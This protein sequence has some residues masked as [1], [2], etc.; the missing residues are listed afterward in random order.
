MPFD[1]SIISPWHLA[2]LLGVFIG[3]YAILSTLIRRR[4][5]AWR[6]YST[7]KP[8]YY[9]G[10]IAALCITAAA[11]LVLEDKNL[12]WGLLGAVCMIVLIGRLDEEKN[13]SPYRQLFWQACIAAWAV[14][15]GW[16][17]SHISDPINGG[18][19]AISF[20]G[21]AA[22]VWFLF[23]MNAINFLDGTDGLATLTGII[24]CIA[25]AGISLLPATQDTTTLALS[26]VGI[27]G[28]AAFF[29]WNAPPARVYLG[30]SGSW[31]LGLFLAM[32]AIIGGGKIATAMI[33]LAIPVLD[34][35]FVIVSRI[36]RKKAPWKGDGKSHI[37]HRLQAFGFSSW[38]ILLALGFVTCALALVAV[39]ASTQIKIIALAVFAVLF[40][41]GRMVTMKRG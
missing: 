1:T 41:A 13:I 18:V 31:F 35:L 15:F 39:L 6:V 32:T 25:L 3:V 37:H 9:A 7:G 30:T 19:M 10:W 27:G 33:V 5:V 11:S 36:M 12:L 38:G 16:T 29:L 8:L 23:C 17:F 21:L 26:F 24:A 28:L 2:A 40:F 4:P 22:F 14:Y 20:G 34:A